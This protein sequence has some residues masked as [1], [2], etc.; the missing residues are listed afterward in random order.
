MVKSPASIPWGSVRAFLQSWHNASWS[1]WTSR[2]KTCAGCPA[3]RAAPARR[4]REA[5][6]RDGRWKSGRRMGNFDGKFWP[7]VENCWWFAGN[8]VMF[9]NVLW[10][11]MGCF[12]GIDVQ[13]AQR[14]GLYVVHLMDGSLGIFGESS[15]NLMTEAWAKVPD[16][17]P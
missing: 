11:F 7:E 2:A 12:M 3:C 6:R 17:L 10:C 9:Y 16:R 4:R 15:W 13:S 1:A 14:L 8:L 5:G